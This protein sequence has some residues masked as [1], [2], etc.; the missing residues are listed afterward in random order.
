ML[1]ASLKR[2]TRHPAGQAGMLRERPTQPL[3]QRDPRTHP[4][5][6]RD[7]QGV[8]NG[9]HAKREHGVWR[10]ARHEPVQGRAGVQVRKR[11]TARALEWEGSDRR[12]HALNRADDL[13]A[14]TWCG[15]RNLVTP[16][17]QRFDERSAEPYEGT[18][19]APDE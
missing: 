11:I 10:F 16:G 17:K 15:C 5:P 2:A 4:Q 12:P 8:R 18:V 19:D 7:R 1:Q 13:T 9:F 14:R 6:L 3:D